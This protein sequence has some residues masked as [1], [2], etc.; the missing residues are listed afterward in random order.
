MIDY[1]KGCV[2]ESL[3]NFVNVKTQDEHIV[4][5]VNCTGC[6]CSTELSQRVEWSVCVEPLTKIPG[7]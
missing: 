2:L 1:H 5:D 7:H 3:V 4:L 6:L